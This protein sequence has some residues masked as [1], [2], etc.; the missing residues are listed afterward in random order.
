MSSVSFESLAWIRLGTSCQEIS[1]GTLCSCLSLPPI[2]KLSHIHDRRKLILEGTE[3]QLCQPNSRLAL[4]S[5]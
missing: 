2:S 4:R 1:Q 3:G 5:E